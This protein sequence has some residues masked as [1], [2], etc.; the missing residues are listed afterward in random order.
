MHHPFPVAWPL[1]YFWS[2][3]RQP[4]LVTLRKKITTYHENHL[5]VSKNRG[6]RPKWMV[7]IMENPIKLDDLGGPLF[8]ETSTSFWGGG[9]KPLRFTNSTLGFSKFLSPNSPACF[10]PHGLLPGRKPWEIFSDFQ[11]NP[12]DVRVFFEMEFRDGVFVA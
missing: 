5:G 3:K 11:G 4:I 10:S 6:K 8:S 9:W 12:E 7:K 2:I 1:G